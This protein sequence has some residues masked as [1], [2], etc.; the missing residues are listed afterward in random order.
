MI[1]AVVDEHIH[2]GETLTMRIDDSGLCR[3]GLLRVGDVG[4]SGVAAR[5]IDKG[6][7]VAFDPASNTRDILMHCGYCRCAC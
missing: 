7:T 2:V 5:D 3:L 6:E 1:D 4:G